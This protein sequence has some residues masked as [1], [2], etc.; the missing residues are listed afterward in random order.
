M[1]AFLEVDY[2]MIIE[3]LDKKIDDLSDRYATHRLMDAHELLSLSEDLIDLVHFIEERSKTIDT[4][5]AANG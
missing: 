2:E 3:Q 1:K 5:E 4:K